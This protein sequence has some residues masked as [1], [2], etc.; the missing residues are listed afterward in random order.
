MRPGETKRGF[1]E[2]ADAHCGR[3][4]GDVHNQGVEAWSSLGFID[5]CDRLG[6]G[7][8]GG[9]AIDRLGRN[10]DRLAGEDQPRSLG[11][12]FV[13]EGKDSRLAC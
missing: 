8:V 13:I 10:R 4:V 7:R 3:E 6:V 12:E 11:D 1:V 9:E 5:S 2:R